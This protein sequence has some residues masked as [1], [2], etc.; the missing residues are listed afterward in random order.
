MLSSYPYITPEHP[1]SFAYFT[2]STRLPKIIQDILD[3][4]LFPSEAIQSKLGQLLSEIPGLPIRRFP[5]L[6]AE[7]ALWEPFFADYE[8]QTL[9]QIPFFFGE[10]YFYRYLLS[11]TEY[12]Q[13]QR[14]PFGKSKEKDIAKNVDFFRKALEEMAFEDQDLNHYLRLALLGNQADLSQLSSSLGQGIEIFLNEGVQLDAAFGSRKDVHLILDNAG[15]ELF[16]DL[17]LADYLLSTGRA[18]TITLHAKKWPLLV[19]DAT[20]G[21]IE[22]LCAALEDQGH[23]DWVN[24]LRTQQAERRLVLTDHL[25]WNSPKHFTQLEEALAAQFSAERAVVITKGD[26]NYRRMFE[27]RVL[28]PTLSPQQTEGTF[29]C[30]TFSLRALKSEIVVGLAEGQAETFAGQDDRW[31]VNGKWALIQQTGF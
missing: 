30:P 31:L 8:G 15:V 16:S 17:V 22:G 20:I 26:A 28:P 3:S 10:I 25:F 6:P 4:G 24:R 21:D 12:E 13:N 9:T 19:S 14:D 7:E 11:L 29:P 1:D 2:L 23:E 27:D 5:L 18:Q